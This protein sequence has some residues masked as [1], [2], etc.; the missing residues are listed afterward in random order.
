MLSTGGVLSVS[1]M[2]KE[3]KKNI[4]N[5]NGSRCR[6]VKTKKICEQGRE[7]NIGHK[8]KQTASI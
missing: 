1:V 7:V 8:I 6:D 3:Y 2:T 4:F 5:K